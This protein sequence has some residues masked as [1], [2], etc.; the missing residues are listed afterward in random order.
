M[1]SQLKPYGRK[2]LADALHF[3][4]AEARQFLLA[5]ISVSLLNSM[6]PARA[7]DGLD[8]L[9]ADYARRN[10]LPVSLVQRVVER[11]SRH[12]P[13]VVHAGCYGLMQ[14]R[15]AT[16]RRM[17]YAGSPHGLLDPATNLTFAVAYLA[18]AY[19]LAKGDE[20]KAMVLYARGY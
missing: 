16:A 9:I 11:E 1:R 13:N 4:P 8:T 15:Y 3:A 20:A 14:I 19:R 7:R 18:N 12:N 6:S 2:K 10:G 5:I 17:G